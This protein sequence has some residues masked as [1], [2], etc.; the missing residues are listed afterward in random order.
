MFTMEGVSITHYS[1]W[2]VNKTEESTLQ[3]TPGVI[4]GFHGGEDGSPCFLGCYAVQPPSSG[5]KRAV[6]WEGNDT[7][8]T[9]P[10]LVLQ[11]WRWRTAW[12]PKRW[13]TT[14]TLHGATT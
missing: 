3:A 11:P 10:W 2:S 8:D 5:L 13:L 14:T 7:L 4:W 9:S 6:C 12:P 1:V